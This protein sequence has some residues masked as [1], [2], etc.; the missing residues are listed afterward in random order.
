VV[1]D[2]TNWNGL[3]AKEQKV[4]V[5][6]LPPFNA[7]NDDTGD[8]GPGIQA[9]INAAA[10]A[11]GGKVLLPAGK[12]R[13][14]SGLT[15]PSAVVLEGN[16][17]ATNL[18]QGDH[19]TNTPTLGSWLH[20][21]DHRVNA[22]S[23]IGPTQGVVLQDFGMYCDQPVPGPNWAPTIYPYFIRLTG[24]WSS[25]MFIHNVILLN[26]SHGI[27]QDSQGEVYHTGQ[28]NIDGLFGQPLVVGVRLE[29]VGDVSRLND[30]HF[31]PFWSDKST[32]T[33]YTRTNATAF[34]MFRVDNPQFNEIFT[35]AYNRM[36][37]LGKNRRGKTSRLKANNVDGDACNTLLRIEPNADRTEV[38][39]SNVNVGGGNLP[40]PVVD[41]Q[42]SNTLFQATNLFVSAIPAQMMSVGGT[43]NT[44]EVS[45]LYCNDW[46]KANRDYCAIENKS[47][48][49]WIS[50]MGYHFESP[51][52]SRR[53][54]YWGGA[55]ASAI[56]RVNGNE[57]LTSH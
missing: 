25:A 44:V 18:R 19:P 48:A 41:I 42:A 49:N 39:F 21:V 1:D 54:R 24:L 3:S 50:V 51:V 29:Y 34:Q 38:S 46:N 8:A 43:S 20:V 12:Y 26:P 30:V 47:P 57:D 56:S 4:F 37:D 9:A 36:F 16:G 13:L 2:G 55:G 23:N 15:M 32:V 11:G 31:W 52:G 14:A 28:L 53:T 45:N 17:W 33:K 10:G 22:I 27:I 5:V 7:P 40:Q 35:Y 6:T